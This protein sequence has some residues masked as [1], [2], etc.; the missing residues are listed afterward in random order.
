MICWVTKLRLKRIASRDANGLYGEFLIQRQRKSEEIPAVNIDFQPSDWM[1]SLVGDYTNTVEKLVNNRKNIVSLFAKIRQY[2]AR[3]NEANNEFDKS[4]LA[5]SSQVSDIEEE[6]ARLEAK[7]TEISQLLN[8][9]HEGKPLPNGLTPR[10]LN[11][12]KVDLEKKRAIKQAQKE[13]ASDISSIQTEHDKLIKEFR[14]EVKQLE[15]ELSKQIDLLYNKIR[16]IEIKY[17]E[18]I[19]YYWMKLCVYIQNIDFQYNNQDSQLQINSVSVTNY[20]EIIQINKPVKKLK[21]I[22]Y[23]CETDLSSKDDL[24]RSERTFINTIIN[25]A[26]DIQYEV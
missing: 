24:F 9:F 20:N 25:Q 2:H 18:Q 6:I 5:I 16:K 7:I 21:D 14:D 11:S 1:K 10:K 4:K 15:Y 12:S 19:S 23:F 17:N 8:D 26:N 22:A 3:L 13:S